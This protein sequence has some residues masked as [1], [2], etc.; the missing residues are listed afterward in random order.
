[1]GYVTFS[2]FA[3]VIDTM[4]L[5]FDRDSI[6]QMFT[7]MDANQDNLLKYPDFCQLCSEFLYRNGGLDDLNNTQVSDP[8][9]NVLRQMKSKSS[10]ARGGSLKTV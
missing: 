2:D 9:L 1:M 6:L 5:G 4:K 8:F 7:Y 10:T 3:Y